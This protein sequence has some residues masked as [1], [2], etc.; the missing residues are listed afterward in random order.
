MSSVIVRK[1]PGPPDRDRKKM[2]QACEIGGSIYGRSPVRGKV[3]GNAG[4]EPQTDL[5]SQYKD[6]YRNQSDMMSK[7]FGKNGKRG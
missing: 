5:V 1:S 2:L 3:P 4:P 7:V 6:L